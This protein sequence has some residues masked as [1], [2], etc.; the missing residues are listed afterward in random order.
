MDSSSVNSELYDVEPHWVYVEIVVHKVIIRIKC[1]IKYLVLHL[2]HK[3][4]MYVD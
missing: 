3:C 4:F 2:A 1:Y